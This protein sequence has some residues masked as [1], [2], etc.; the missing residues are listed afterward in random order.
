MPT[1]KSIF[2]LIIIPFCCLSL[3]FACPTFAANKYQSVEGMLSAQKTIRVLM[4]LSPGFGNQAATINMMNRLRQ[5]HFSGKYEVIYPDDMQEK[6][7]SLFNL[8]KTLP[9]VYHYEDANQNKI[10]FILL[11]YYFKQ[12]KNN[13][14]ESIP[15]AIS[16]AHDWDEI[17]NCPD[18]QNDTKLSPLAKRNFR[19]KRNLQ[20]GNGNRQVAS[21]SNCEVYTNFAKFMKADVHVQ[22]QPWYF[23]DPEEGDYIAIPSSAKIK[24]M[25][26]GKYWIY[27]FA[28][29]ADA[30]NYLEQTK[31]GRGFAVQRPGLSS[32]INQISQQ[33]INFMSVYGFDFQ[34]KYNYPAEHDYP[35]PQNILQVLT[36][37][38]FT[39]MS[40]GELSKP[41]IVAVYYDYKAEINELKSLLGSANWGE[42][43]IIGGQQARAAIHAVGL[44][45]PQIFSLASL[46]DADV[47]QKINSLAPGQILLLS[48]GPL[49]KVV[50]D[51]LY[52][53]TGSN[54]WPAIREGEG[55]LSL[56]LQTGKPH[57]RCVGYYRT[58]VLSSRWEP[59]FDLVKDSKLKNAMLSF[60]QD[61]GFCD[62]NSWKK[63]PDIYKQLGNFIIDAKNP[64]SL[65][66]QY[67]SDVKADSLILKNDRIHRGLEEAMKIMNKN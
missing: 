50:F 58:E 67:F 66:S 59:G 63:N 53:H 18:E 15:L 8:P 29:F 47:S 13:L 22:L 7:I 5:M 44:D 42:Y 45:N 62:V 9:A 48:M 39:Q 57:F 17:D 32:L 43:E 25:P 41:L 52:S 65:L 51:G 33:K 40:G 26:K 3:A 1:P 10:D 4:D 49:P 14:V 60:Y 21:Q 19:I 56:L 28:Q 36:A 20:A 27:P 35:F 38:R 12:L 64:S 2:K 23:Q 61:N 16:G 6:I 55:S 34:K 37:A 31:E 11:S 46:D 54:I 30:K 24:I